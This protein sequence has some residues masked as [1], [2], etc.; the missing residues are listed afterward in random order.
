M[1][2]ICPIVRVFSE[3]GYG[4]KKVLCV[5]VIYSGTSDINFLSAKAGYRI[6][7]I[8]SLITLV[9]WSESI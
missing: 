7:L 4:G 2:I 1:Q 5:S 9:Q 3:L 6:K 8:R